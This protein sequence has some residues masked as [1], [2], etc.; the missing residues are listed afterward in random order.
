ML[1]WNL[2]IR[3]LRALAAICRLGSV[4]AAAQTIGLSQP[5]VTQGMARLELQL[6][7]TLFE[8]RK[9]GMIPTEAGAILCAQ[10]EKAM[11]I[12][13]GG[14]RRARGAGRSEES[15]VGKEC[16]STCKSRW[17]EDH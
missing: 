17:W 4:S 7:R 1:L 5:A 8:R 11:T 6:G 14:I 9:E 10:S 13:S 12:L 2:N 16:V 15:R 3:H